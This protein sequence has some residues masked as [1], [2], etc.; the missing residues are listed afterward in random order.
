MDHRLAEAATAVDVNT[1]V[2]LPDVT[3]V[4]LAD[5]VQLP[6]DTRPATVPCPYATPIA[7]TL[8][9]AARVIEERG[10]NRGSLVA[11][12]GRAVCL[13]GALRTAA[14][15][16]R[17]LETDAAALLLDVIA[18]TSATASPRCPRSTTTRTPDRPTPCAPWTAPPATPTPAPSNP[19]CA[20]IA[21][22]DG[23]AALRE[24]D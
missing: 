14:G 16:N 6:V 20:R 3:P 24:Q 21:T 18:A 8:W 7:S 9:A 19:G 13:L 15:G 4:A 12:T 22:A 23:H 17:G 2:R 11:D 5:V 1:A 10:H